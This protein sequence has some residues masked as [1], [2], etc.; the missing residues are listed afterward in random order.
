MKWWLVAVGRERSLVFT[1]WENRNALPCKRQ[2]L[3]PHADKAIAAAPVE[4]YAAHAYC[5]S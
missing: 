4:R 1:A 5:S 3:A 2:R